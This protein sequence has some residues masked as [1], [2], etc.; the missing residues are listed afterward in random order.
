M[1]RLSRWRGSVRE[2][3][4]MSIMEDWHP[5][6]EEIEPNKY[7]V[8]SQSSNKGYTVTKNQDTWTCT[9]PDHKIRLHDCKHIIVVQKHLEIM[10]H[11]RKGKVC[12]E[13][14]YD[15]ILK[16]YAQTHGGAMTANPESVTCPLCRDFIRTVIVEEL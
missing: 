6:Y 1:K 10:D 8:K 14:Y 4:A 3:K 16:M 7:Q 13:N 12:Y 2:A 11:V 15:Y 9:C 5:V